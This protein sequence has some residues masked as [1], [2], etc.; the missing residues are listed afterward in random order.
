MTHT[1]DYPFPS[2][3][4]ARFLG[5]LINTP[6][7][8]KRFMDQNEIPGEM[9]R[10]V[11]KEFMEMMAKE[12]LKIAESRSD[13]VVVDTRGTLLNE[14]DWVNEIH[15]N[16]AGFNAIADRMFVEIEKYFPALARN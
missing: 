13:F 6:G 14:D 3:K 7:W 4:G 11:I 1:Y 10:D 12:S 5:G 8:M 9:Q 16:R 15:P 2:L